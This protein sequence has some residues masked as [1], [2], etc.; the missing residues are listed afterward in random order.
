MG[1]SVGYDFVKKSEAEENFVEE[2]GR[3]FLGGD[4]FLSRAKNYP[5][6]KPMVYHDQE[7]VKARGDGKICDE[8]ARNLLERARGDGLMGDKGGTVGCVLTLFCW[9]IAQP[10][11]YR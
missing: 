8:I 6:S 9:H 4:G 10:L 5:L 2:K 3:D 11:M 1:T 7:R